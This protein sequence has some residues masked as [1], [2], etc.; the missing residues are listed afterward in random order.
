MKSVALTLDINAVILV[1][2]KI[3][4]VME[5]VPDNIGK[6][7]LEIMVWRNLREGI[8]KSLANTIDWDNHGYADEWRLV[9]DV[10]HI[11]VD[12]V[13]SWDRHTVT[14]VWKTNPPKLDYDNLKKVDAMYEESNADESV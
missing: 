12:N 7:D 8:D 4:V 10:C 11:Q 5:N 2:G 1:P 9:N 14:N 3:E 6:H 13:K